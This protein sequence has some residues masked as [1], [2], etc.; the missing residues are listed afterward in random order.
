VRSASFTIAVDGLAA[1][2]EAIAV[3]DGRKLDEFDLHAAGRRL[4]VEYTT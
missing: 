1:Q 4:L 3:D 2:L